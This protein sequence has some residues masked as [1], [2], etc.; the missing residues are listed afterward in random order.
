MS[1]REKLGGE[2]WSTINLAVHGLGGVL[3]SLLGRMGWVYRRIL[4]EAGEISLAIPNLRTVRR[5]WR[6]LSY[7]F[8]ILC[9]YRQQI[10]FLLW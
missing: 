5:L 7:Y 4:G 3:M 2:W 9:I 10:L 6:S 8:S 1:M